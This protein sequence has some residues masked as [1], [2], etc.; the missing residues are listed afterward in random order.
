MKKYFY[1]KWL[2]P[3]FS[4]EQRRLNAQIGQNVNE[5]LQAGGFLKPLSTVEEI[6]SDIGVPA[7]LLGIYMRFHYGKTLLTW[8]KDLRIEEAKRLLLAYP[9]LPIA[10][11]GEMVGIEDKSNFRRQ[12]TGKVKMTPGEWRRRYGTQT[13]SIVPGTGS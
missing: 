6:S 11:V 3:V 9:Q 7:D 1:R 5:W 13:G 8:R 10:T 4:A 12:F 2:K